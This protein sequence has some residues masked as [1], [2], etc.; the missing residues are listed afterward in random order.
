MRIH[1][2]GSKWTSRLPP[3]SWPVSGRLPWKC[4]GRGVGG[5]RTAIISGDRCRGWILRK[6]VSATGTDSSCLGGPFAAMCWGNH[7]TAVYWSVQYMK[8]GV[9]GGISPTVPPRGARSVTD[10]VVCVCVGGDCAAKNAVEVYDTETPGWSLWHQPLASLGYTTYPHIHPHQWSWE[11]PST[12][13]HSKPMALE[14]YGTRSLWHSKPLALETGGIRN[15]WHS[16]PMVL[17]T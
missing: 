11:D 15:R 14:A 1:G 9:G 16:K 5:G 12:L 3:V 17:E 8:C 13:V 2:P 7:R 10:T 4:E 6:C